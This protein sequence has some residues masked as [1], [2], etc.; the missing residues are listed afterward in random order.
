MNRPA[1]SIHFARGPLFR[2]A[3]VA[4]AFGLLAASSPVR[5]APDS[6]STE[7]AL[8]RPQDWKLT[9]PGAEA[10]ALAAGDSARDRGM[11]SLEIRYA[12][13]TAANDYVFAENPSPL[14]A[15]PKKARLMLRSDG[16]GVSLRL[17]VTDASGEFFQAYLAKAVWQGWKQVEVPLEFPSHW[18]G[19]KNG[20]MDGQI[21]FH[22]LVVNS[23]KDQTRT[24]GSL[25][26]AR[27]ELLSDGARAGAAAPVALGRATSITVDDFERPNPLRAYQIWRGDDSSID[28]VSSIEHKRNGNFSMQITYTLSTSRSAPTWVSASFTPDRPLNWTGA[29]RISLWVKGDGTRNG[30]QIS[31]VD[32]RKSVWVYRKPN[33]LRD[34]GW[35]LLQADLQDFQPIAG[36]TGESPD[37]ARIVKYEFVIQGES[38]EPSSGRIWLDDFIVTGTDLNPAVA[39]PRTALSA[40]VIEKAKVDVGDSLHVEYRSTP[41]FNRELLFFNKLVLKGTA[42]NVSLAADLVS[43]QADAGRTIPFQKPSAAAPPIQPEERNRPDVEIGYFNAA[44]LNL[45]PNLTTLSVGN[46]YVDYGRDVFSP[47]FGFKGAQ[48]DGKVSGVDYNVF[49][50]KHIYDAFTAGARLQKRH[51]GV[52]F[53]GMTVTYRDTA[54]SADKSVI[55]TGPVAPKTG[56]LE[57]E[58]VASDDVYFLDASR[59]FWKDK[60]DLS[61]AYAVNHF[62]QDALK[63]V[64][65]PEAPVISQE[66]FAP[67]SKR[68]QMAEG[69]VRVKKI[70]LEGTT[71]IAGYRHFAPNYR[72]FFRGDPFRYDHNIAD[73]RGH[74]LEFEQI[75]GRWKLNL[76]YDDVDRGPR[77]RDYFR[78]TFRPTLGIYNINRWDVVF[79]VNRRRELYALND[80]LRSEVFIDPANPRNE[81][82]TLYELFLG[83]WFTET[84]SVWGKFMIEDLTLVSE[85]RDVR[86]DIMVLQSDYAIYENA[87]LAVSVLQTRFDDPSFE[88]RASG[89]NFVRTED[90]TED[91]RVRVTLDINF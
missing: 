72:P 54:R 38:A 73:V 15:A 50:I 91:N 82:S 35:T 59:G 44:I 36:Q 12:F 46:L 80:P 89:D 51:A 37:L 2:G 28:P 66:P 3:R 61:A 83:H 40:D 18:D 17:N 27:L 22:S 43:A 85:K 87:R 7:I 74:S 41:E 76:F 48:A 20:K 52:L 10:S 55:V 58:T 14:T 70:P 1:F 68:G 34:V 33:I 23:E 57:T 63:D 25:A 39:A 77:S 90:R 64:T 69:K 88:P 9:G 62:R 67:V 31:L 84:F 47:L 8:D 6:I 65:A 16:S 13:K 56:E 60:L 4:A 78:R 42:K 79:S 24:Q 29:K 26:V 30:L 81:R 19:D 21:S 5:G 71:L 11:A 86:K 53:R 49:A 45:H 32:G 75:L